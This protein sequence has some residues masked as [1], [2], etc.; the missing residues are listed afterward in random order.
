MYTK[1]NGGSI[2]EELMVE[3]M[4]DQVIPPHFF[5]KLPDRQSQD[6]VKHLQQQGAPIENVYE[7]K[8][9]STVED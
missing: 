1:L 8:L 5:F 4:S 2:E 3:L 7:A 6:W 9:T